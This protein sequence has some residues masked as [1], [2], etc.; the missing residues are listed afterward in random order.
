M[1]SLDKTLTAMGTMMQENQKET[2]AG[3]DALNKRI[4]YILNPRPAQ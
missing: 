3:L 1:N 4:D 2:R